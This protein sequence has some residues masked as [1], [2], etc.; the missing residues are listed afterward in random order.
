MK[1]NALYTKK[2][3][4]IYVHTQNKIKEKHTYIKAWRAEVFVMFLQ[5]TVKAITLFH[6][7]IY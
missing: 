4:I 6:A 1:K 5:V 7:G 3:K 2:K